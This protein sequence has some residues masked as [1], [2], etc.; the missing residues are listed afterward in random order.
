MI[1]FQVN[2]L[3]IDR[4]KQFLHGMPKHPIL[5]SNEEFSIIFDEE[6]PIDECDFVVIDTEMT[7]LNPRKH[8]IISIGAV[9]VHKMC[10]SIG[11]SFHSYVRAARPSLKESTLVHHITSEQLDAAP[12][13]EEVIPK[14]VQFCGGSVLVGHYLQLDMGFINRAAKRILGGALSNRRMDC[15]RLARAHLGYLNRAGIKRISV[16]DTFYLSKLAKEYGLPLFVPHDA[17]EDAMQTAYLFLFLVGK[18]RDYGLMTFR[19]FQQA[20]D[21]GLGEDDI[22]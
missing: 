22:I 14:F 8:E 17:L 13:L 18:L 2:R 10:I 5:T 16:D 7:G 15:A 20:S 11:E 19:D 1:C 12:E 3:F 9:K 21:R 6:R 4:L